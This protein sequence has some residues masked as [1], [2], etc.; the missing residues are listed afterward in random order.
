MVAERKSILIVRIW[1]SHFSKRIKISNILFFCL[2]LQFDRCGSIRDRL[3]LGFVSLQ[4]IILIFAEK[5]Q[6]QL[7]QQSKHELVF[8]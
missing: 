3:Q 7:Q 4:L 6:Q 1:L 8:N 2:S 5:K